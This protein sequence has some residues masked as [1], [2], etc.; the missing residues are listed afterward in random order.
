MFMVG[1]SMIEITT[2]KEGMR[3]YNLEKLTINEEFFLHAM[4]DIQSCG[5]SYELS[6]LIMNCVH[7]NPT[8]RPSYQQFLA[9][10]HRLRLRST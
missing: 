4:N 10:I 8:L 2:I 1:L 5:Y 9:A 6:N 7:K 3:C